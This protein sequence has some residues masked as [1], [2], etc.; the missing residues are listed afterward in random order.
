MTFLS[1]IHNCTQIP[2]T[3]AGFPKELYSTPARTRALCDFLT[4]TFGHAVSSAGADVRKQ[5]GGWAGAKGGDMNVDAPGV[6]TNGYILCRKGG[7]MWEKR[8]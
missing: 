6:D 5:S 1:T 8:K 7:C 2:A 3:V 4:R